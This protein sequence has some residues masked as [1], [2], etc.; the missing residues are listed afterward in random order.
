MSKF[1][2]YSS[3]KHEYVSVC[4]TNLSDQAADQALCSRAI[5][6]PFGCIW[7]ASTRFSWTSWIWCRIISLS[8]L[9]RAPAATLLGKNWFGL[10]VVHLFSLYLSATHSLKAKP[11]ELGLYMWVWIDSKDIINHLL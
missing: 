9:N 3:N 10:V 5:S 11:S 4:T 1:R 2:C 7:I 6:G 8:H